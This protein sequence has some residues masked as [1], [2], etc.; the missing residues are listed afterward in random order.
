MYVMP[1]RI[2]APTSKRGKSLYEQREVCEAVGK[3]LRSAPSRRLVRDMGEDSLIAHAALEVAPFQGCNPAA[4]T[5]RVGN[6]EHGCEESA[7]HLHQGQSRRDQRRL[8]ALRIL[9]S[10]RSRTFLVADSQGVQS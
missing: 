3:E 9:R 2:G 4:A 10:H 6:A 7:T 8:S 5:T 1:S